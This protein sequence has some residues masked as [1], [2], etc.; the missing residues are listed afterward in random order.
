MRDTLR[1]T[2]FQTCSSTTGILI[3]SPDQLGL[4]V[5]AS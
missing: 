1:A 3:H 2:S 4:V 5:V